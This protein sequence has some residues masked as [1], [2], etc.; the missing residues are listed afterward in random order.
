MVTLYRNLPSSLWTSLWIT[1]GCSRLRTMILAR[2]RRRV[3]AS[4]PITFTPN[5]KDVS[6]LV[7]LN[8]I[9]GINF[10]LRSTIYAFYAGAGG[11][12]IERPAKS[13][14][15]APMASG[16]CV[17]GAKGSTLRRCPFIVVPSGS[18]QILDRTNA[19]GRGRLTVAEAPATT[20]EPAAD[21]ATTASAA[22]TTTARRGC[23]GEA[24]LGAA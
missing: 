12:P 15:D 11:P 17:R 16:W 7:S 19:T 1:W 18:W 9:F 10:P 2:S 24:V 8:S 14:D 4:R 3:T 23:R 22:T 13:S 6:H 5:T 20:G 21:P